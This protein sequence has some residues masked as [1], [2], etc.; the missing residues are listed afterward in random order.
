MKEINKN[1]EIYVFS[2][3]ELNDIKGGVNNMAIVSMKNASKDGDGK[4]LVCCTGN[5]KD[6]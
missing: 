6:Q 4:A 1:Q 5:K 3:K 2:D